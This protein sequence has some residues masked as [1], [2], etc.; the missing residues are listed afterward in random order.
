MLTNDYQY[1][2]LLIAI[3]EQ[4]RSSQAKAALAVNSA[5]IQLYW[6][7]GEM[8]AQNQVLFD[9]RNNY[10]E[11]LASDIKQEFPNMPGFSRRNLFDIRRF[12]LFYSSVSVRQLAAL[13]STDY[14]SINSVQQLAS[15]DNQPISVRQAAA[16]S[17][18]DYQSINSV[19]QVVARIPWGHHLLILNKVK[20]PEQALF[21][22]QQTIEYNW[23]RAILALQI[24][25]NLFARQGKAFNNFK[26]TLPEQQA[27]I[28]QQMLK[29]PYNF[30]FLA[31]EP[32]IQELDIEKQL[33]EHITKF[34]L[35]LGKGFA[36]IGRQYPLEVGD[37]EYRLDL[38]FYH[39]R[40]RSFVVIDLKTGTFEPEFAGKM[41]FYLSVI[42]DQLKQETD[43]PTI[44][45][46]LCKGKRGIEVEYALRGINKP[47]GIS[48]FIITQ[49]LPA[50]LKSNIPTIEE[51]EKELN[52]NI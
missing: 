49:A 30:A 27:L 1:R 20:D 9:G 2:E 6:K 16:L 44:G 40:L 5:V 8:I 17:S 28:A 26:N 4:I 18:T 37:K 43:Q 10:I 25:Q 14:Q 42:D 36:F 41:N 33:T 7:I 35:E 15:I 34:L 45:I 3:K 46:I 13:G 39:I 23:T 48:E 24:E 11:Q 21:Y 47:I 12:Y 31:L 32:Q 52:R 29:D 22:I 51:F 38:L 50:E 19:Q